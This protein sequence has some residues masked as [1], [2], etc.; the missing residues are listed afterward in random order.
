MQHPCTFPTTHTDTDED[1]DISHTHT[2]TQAPTAFIFAIYATKWLWTE[3][4]HQLI[5]VQIEGIGQQEE[6]TQKPDVIRFRPCTYTRLDHALTRNTGSRLIP[7]LLQL[8]FPLKDDIT[9][10]PASCFWQRQ[11]MGVWVCFLCVHVFLCVEYHDVSDMY[12]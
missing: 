8:T 4:S 9:Q 1:T 2:H 5:L 3:W 10:L 12:Y 6:I 7:S 11:R